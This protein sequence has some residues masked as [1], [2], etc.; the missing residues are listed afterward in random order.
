MFTPVNG[1][2][3]AAAEKQ[4]A[5]PKAQAEINIVRR[6]DLILIR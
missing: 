6:F 5:A 3:P 4:A 1:S 2:G